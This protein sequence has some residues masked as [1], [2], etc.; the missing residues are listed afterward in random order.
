[1]V[2]Q[3][4]PERAV[5][6]GYGTDAAK[7]T[8]TV[9][10]IQQNTSHTVTVEKRIWRV[11][12]DPMKPGGPYLLRAV[13][14]SAEGVQVRNLTDVLFGDVW[15]CGGQS[16]MEMTLLQVMNASEEL[17]DLTKYPTV[18]VFTAALEMSDMELTDLPRVELVWTLPSAGV[19]G[20][21]NFTHFS[22]VCWLFGRYLYESRRHPVG[23]VES[24][25]GGTPVEAWSSERALQMCGLA[26]PKHS[27]Q[28]AGASWDNTVLWNAM[29]HPLLNMTIKG[30]IWYQ[31]ESNTEYHQ[32]LYN[33]TFPAMIDD[34]RMAFHQGSGGQTSPVFP[35]GFVQLS[36]YIKRS[37]SDAFPNLRWHQTADYGFAP[38]PRMKNTF[39]AVS[40]DLGDEASPWGSIHPRYKQDVAHRLTLGA[41]AVAY[42]E[43]GVSFQG[44]F[45][46]DIR[47]QGEYINITYSEK[48]SVTKSHTAFEVCCS[49][50]QRDHRNASFAW[51]RAPI[52]ETSSNVVVL[53]TDKCSDEVAALRYAWRD[54]PCQLKACP[55]YSAD[56]ALPAAP[57]MLPVKS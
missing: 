50:S 51:V 46:Q 16:N 56:H 36:T 4:A 9:L 27:F 49:S 30:A 33:C 14:Q 48:V 1:M 23:L 42:G 28:N 8:I 13:Q 57:F 2:L 6:W 29:I 22:A 43:K 12:L 55:V 24:C 52:V 53:S 38:N 17:S 19:L 31:G 39:M 5:L 26:K 45:P 35:F 20:G 34:W 15:L 25:W 37:L 10:G 47:L 32:D 44:P 40:L 54:W 18:R 3:R 11:T 7:V 21:G 41:R